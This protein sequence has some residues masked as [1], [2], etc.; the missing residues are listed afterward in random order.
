MSQTKKKSDKDFPIDV[1]ES[2]HKVW[3]AGLGAVSVAEEKGS[4]FFKRLVK[5]GEKYEERRKEQVEKVVDRVKD[6]VEDV[7]EEVETR[8]SK[9]GD[10]F[11]RK[12]AQAVERLGVPTREE[13]HK[14]TVRV[15]DLTAQLDKLQPKTGSK[16][17]RK[18]GAT[19][20][21]A[22]KTVQKTA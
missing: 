3:L 10:S 15:E 2:A 6:G 5:R 22:K 7:R 21:A 12:V 18:S 4:E 8:W 1:K 20:A 9:L 16:R 13:I 19:K 11:D 14:L 17:T